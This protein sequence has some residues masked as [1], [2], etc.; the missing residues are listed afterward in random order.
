MEKRIVVVA[1]EKTPSLFKPLACYVVGVVTTAVAVSAGHG[2]SGLICFGL[3]ILYYPRVRGVGSEVAE[4][5]RVGCEAAF[6]DCPGPGTEADPPGTG[7]HGKRKAQRRPGSRSGAQ[8]AG[9]RKNESSLGREAGGV[10]SSQR[11]PGRSFTAGHRL[12]KELTP[13]CSTNL[14]AGWSKRT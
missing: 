6:P 4:T 9:L 14:T 3:G 13:P 2:R 1:A 8:G 7:D 11:K 5:R 10:R 12:R